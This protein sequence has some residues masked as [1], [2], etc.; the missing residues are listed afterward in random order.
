MIQPKPYAFARKNLIEC[1]V[2]DSIRDVA[3]IF[4]DESVGS[5]LVKDESGSY[6]GMLTDSIVFKAI[7]DDVDVRSMRVRDF[8][9][10]P[11]VKVNKNADL[12]EVMEAFQ[13]HDVS[14]LAMTDDNGRIVGVLRKKFM[15]RFGSFSMASSLYSLKK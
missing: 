15:E 8:S 7:A 10:M 13:K 1:S 9:L 11:L 5:A 3:R 4:Q 2:G 12:G 6:I 14:R